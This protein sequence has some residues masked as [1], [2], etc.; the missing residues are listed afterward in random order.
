MSEVRRVLRPQA[1]AL[2]IEH[3]AA[4][5]QSQPLVRAQQ[6]CLV[7]ASDLDAFILCICV[8]LTLSAHCKSQALL[9][10]LQISLADGCHLQRN[11]KDNLQTAGFSEL[12]LLSENLQGISSTISPHVRGIAVK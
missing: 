10:P 1:Q 6:V 4:P 7:H 3:V 9:D 5:W 11:T 12:S 8:I 2:F